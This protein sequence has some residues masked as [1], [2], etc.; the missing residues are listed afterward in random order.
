MV[1]LRLRTLGLRTQDFY[2][3]IF[4]RMRLSGKRILLGITGSIAAIKSPVVARELMRE[5]ADIFPVMTDSAAEFTTASA[6]SALTRHETISQIFPREKAAAAD[7]GTWHIHLARSADA[8][9]IAPCSASTIGKLR[10]GI[11]DNP[12]VLLAASL[13]KG[14]PLILAPAMDEEMWLQS[15]VQ[16][17]IAALKH[18]GVYIISP[19]SGPLA[20]GLTG[21]GRMPEPIDLV[22]ELISIL[23]VAGPLA[24]KNILITGGPTYE[25]IDAVRFIGNRSSGKMAAALANAAKKLGAEVTLIMGP[26]PIG[27]NGS[28]ERVDVETAEEML[29]AVQE[30]ALGADIIIM[31][32][33]V[34]D[35][36]PEE[37]SESKLKKR[38][39]M[40]ER[41]E[42]SLRLKQTPDI[43]SRI[44]ATKRPGQF[45]VG[46]ALEKGDEAEAYARA[47]LQE[48]DLDMIV[49]NNI[50]DSGA[51]YGFDTN[52]VT[53]FTR[54]GS[55]EDFPLMSKEECAR[56]ILDSIIHLI[57]S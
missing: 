21:M 33:A 1:K 17:N 7:A 9:L 44:A 48:K 37:T 16:K 52:K 18:D 34:S 14:T 55:R 29:H 43:L 36:A 40:G 50:A 46:F 10:A 35:F 45:I 5:G 51:G 49:L 47:K 2:N 12:V 27:T 25:P 57:H 53:V 41:G 26:S 8:M 13:A 24:G 22:E 32:A 39:M 11:Y 20:S 38:Q 19:V 4:A 56:H 30:L 3:R 23:G 42:V 54:G 28:I 6:M 31:N 15:A